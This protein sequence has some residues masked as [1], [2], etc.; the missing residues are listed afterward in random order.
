MNE[1]QPT[2]GSTRHAGED[3]RAVGKAVIWLTTYECHLFVDSESKEVTHKYRHR[4][5]VD[6]KDPDLCID[7]PM[8]KNNKEMKQ[9]FGEDKTYHNWYFYT[10]TLSVESISEYDPDKGIFV[11]L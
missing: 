8:E 10:N 4:V 6:N 1:I 11:D 3:P 5:N 9:L 2:I 7:E